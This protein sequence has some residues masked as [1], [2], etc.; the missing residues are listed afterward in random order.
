LL[1]D[2]GIRKPLEEEPEVERQEVTSQMEEQQA[3]QQPQE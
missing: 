1:Y 3:K 2:D